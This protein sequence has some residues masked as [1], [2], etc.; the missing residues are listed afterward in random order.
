MTPFI[1]L[2]FTEHE[3]EEDYFRIRTDGSVIF[4]T[5]YL[6]ARQKYFGKVAYAPKGTSY[7]WETPKVR[8]ADA[9]FESVTP[10]SHP[11]L[12]V[13]SESK[14]S[15]DV[16]RNNGYKLTYDKNKAD[17]IVI[18]SMEDNPP[19]MAC[20]FAFVKKDMLHLVHVDRA[21]N[22]GTDFT[23]EEFEAVKKEILDR[24]SLDENELIFEAGK[25]MKNFNLFFVKPCEEIGGLLTSSNNY[26]YTKKHVFDSSVLYEGTTKISPDTLVLWSKISDKSMLE[27]AILNSDWKDYPVTMCIFLNKENIDPQYRFGNAGRVM[28]DAINYDLYRR[29]GSLG[30]QVVSAKDWNMLQ[31]YLM[32]RFGV[33]EKGGYTKNVYP[34][35][36]FVRHKMAVVP[37][38]IDS[39][40]SF[41]N[42]VLQTDD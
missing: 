1:E 5:N 15:R 39:P 22:N 25:K 21:V 31:S 20:R 42:L 40:M 27:K 30:D 28:L 17:V 6:F 34:Y 12:F 35:D 23:Q 26:F 32:L 13:C 41:K 14:I 7:S 36:D 37:T 24:F 29:E 3:I 4:R 11:I 2:K 33:S 38:M 10:S 18:P 16:L 8:V 19:V 9:C